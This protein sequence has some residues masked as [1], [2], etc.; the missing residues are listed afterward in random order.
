MLNAVVIYCH[1]MMLDNQVPDRLKMIMGWSYSL[2]WNA[3]HL[4]S[5]SSDA[6][7]W[8]LTRITCQQQVICKILLQA[9][10]NSF[11]NL[12]NKPVKQR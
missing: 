4:L 2:A 12:Q 8:T 10:D 3:N 6:L 11:Q 7:G 5:K 9:C 1:V